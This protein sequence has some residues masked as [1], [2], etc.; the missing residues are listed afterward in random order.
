M[1]PIGKYLF[2]FY[3]YVVYNNFGEEYLITVNYLN[4]K[5]LLEEIHKSKNTYSSYSKPEYHQYDIILTNTNKINIRTIAEAKRNRA[6]RL[7]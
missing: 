3:N 4:N 7:S 2:D 6:R 1:Y 5:D